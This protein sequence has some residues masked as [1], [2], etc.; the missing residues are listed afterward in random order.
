MSAGGNPCQCGSFVLHLAHSELVLRIPLRLIIAMEST[1]LSSAHGTLL[2]N[3]SEDIITYLMSSQP[4]IPVQP[5]F[6]FLSGI[7]LKAI[8]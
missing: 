5:G 4:K 8:S 1:H 3:L 7:I 6:T 2:E